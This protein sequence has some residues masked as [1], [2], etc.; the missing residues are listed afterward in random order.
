MLL[1]SDR[2][3]IEE[4]PQLKKRS[5]L[6]ALYSRSGGLPFI[7]TNNSCII[8]TDLKK[9]EKIRLPTPDE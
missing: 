7:S 2:P 8:A 6:E 4:A 3:R 1:F 5:S 9:P